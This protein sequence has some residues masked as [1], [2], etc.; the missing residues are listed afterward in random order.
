[1][2][3]LHRILSLFVAVF[4]L[5]LGLTGMAIQLTDLRTLFTHAPATDPNMMAIREGFDGPG[6][7]QVIVTGDYTAP[8]L[9]DEFDFQA[10]LPGALGAARSAFGNAGLDYAEF[11]MSDRG[12]V[13]NFESGRQRL[14]FDLTSAE[15]IVAPTPRREQSMVPSFRNTL[16][17]L[18]RMTYF[19]DWPLWINPV[20]GVALGMFVVTGL[21]MYLQLLS[22]R[23][24]MKRAGLFWSAGGGW[25][26]LH[27]WLSVCAAAF[28][29]VV[30]LSGTWLAVESLVFGMYLESQQPPPGQPRPA[31]PS[32]LTPLRDAELPAMLTTTLAAHR[33]LA[34]GQ[35]VK[36]LRLRIYGGMPQAIVI[37]GSGEATR[38]EAFDARTGRAVT[39]TEPGYPETGFPFGWQAHQIAKAVHRGDYIGL[40]GRWMDLFA[41]VSIVFLSTSGIVMYINMWGR[42]RQ[43]GRPAIIWK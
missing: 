33:E 34:P 3:S 36:A 29:L 11:R 7:F 2:R 21:L 24:R 27:R 28:I 30:A 38:Q 40:S 39:L 41:G 13:A 20:V 17:W 19:G 12:P 10:A 1:M 42:R 23:R 8:A 22:A 32:P 26:T 31:R 18:H 16:K 37:A 15:P 9:P 14:R 43:G 25:R 6:D 4:L 35:P 5:Y